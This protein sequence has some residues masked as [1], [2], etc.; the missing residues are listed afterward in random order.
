VRQSSASLHPGLVGAPTYF[1][2]DAEGRI[3]WR[4][5]G[6]G[7]SIERDLAATVRKA[8]KAVHDASHAA[9]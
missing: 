3:A 5:A 2:L 9:R 6:W 8:L 4:H 1:V 7:D